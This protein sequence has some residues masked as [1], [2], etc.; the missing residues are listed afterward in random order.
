MYSEPNINDFNEVF[1]K[2]EGEVRAYD[3]LLP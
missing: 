2:F 1:P 3:P